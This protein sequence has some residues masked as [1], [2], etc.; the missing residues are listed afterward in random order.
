M[1]V[2]LS[3]RRQALVSRRQAIGLL[4]A[5]CVAP[6]A[7]AASGRPSASDPSAPYRVPGGRIG[8]QRPQGIAPTTNGW[9]LQSGDHTFQ[10]RVQET[11]FVPGA[12]NPL[13]DKD[14]TSTLVGT[15]AFEGLSGRR[16]KDLRFLQNLDFGHESIVAASE[17]WVGEVSVSISN[18]GD[19]AETVSAAPQ[20]S[21]VFRP[22]GGPGPQAA[23]LVARW[24]AAA[25]LVLGS[26][27]VRA[28][29]TADVAMAEFGLKLDAAGLNPRFAGDRLILSAQAPR[30]SAEV[31]GTGIAHVVLPAVSNLDYIAED[32]N[33]E[34][35][36]FFS[37]MGV[38]R[39]GTACRGVQAE[40][41]R[42]ANGFA[43]AGI[44]AFGKRRQQEITAIYPAAERAATLEALSRTFQS[45]RFLDEA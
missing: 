1:T 9:I 24:K 31:M 34:L 20:P 37:M 28:A 30:N 29:P 43:T 11:L 8:F 21:G 39:T 23:G 19:Q 25:D 13:W 35:F 6:R 4:G 22:A 40:E 16:F 42:L 7:F 15:P 17:D 26:I 18:L 32:A 2:K 44:R 45:L 3:T 14:A 36:E 33:Q 27:S 41:R 38:A 12:A 5:G 10:V